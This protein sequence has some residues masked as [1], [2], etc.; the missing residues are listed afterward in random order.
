MITSDFLIDRYFWQIVWKWIVYF[1]FFRFTKRFTIK[2]FKNTLNE[3]DIIIFLNSRTRWIIIKNF[4]YHR[5]TL[6]RW[7]MS[8]F[9]VDEF[10]QN[11]RRYLNYSLKS[12]IMNIDTEIHVICIMKLERIKY[13][14]F[15]S[16]VEIINA[17][18]F[19]QIYHITRFEKCRWRFHE[20]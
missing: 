8:I 16:F 3:F 17:N 7:L 9:H 4:F 2:M 12:K 10:W 15:F 20:K 14:L 5:M 1:I 19:S 13:W 6:K 11:S 18:C